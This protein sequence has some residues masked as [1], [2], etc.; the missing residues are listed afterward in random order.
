MR[1]CHIGYNQN[2]IVCWKTFSSILYLVKPKYIL[3]YK[4][5][6]V[7][8]GWLQ[9]P[10][11]HR[12]LPDESQTQGIHCF[13][14][15]V[16]CSFSLR[17]ITEICASR[18]WN[19]CVESL[20]QTRKHV[21]WLKK[22]GGE[23]HNKTP[24]SVL[25]SSKQQKK[26]GGCCPLVASSE[27]GELEAPWRSRLQH[28]RQASTQFRIHITTLNFLTTQSSYADFALLRETFW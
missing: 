27:R 8:M 3:L 7:F 12:P 5:S 28:H 21:C 10:R 6:S 26:T 25:P 1:S 4:A 18:Y 24:K 22:N 9:G 15:A 13:I 14:S 17:G 23:K 20:H 16:R 19:Y 11:H 2:K